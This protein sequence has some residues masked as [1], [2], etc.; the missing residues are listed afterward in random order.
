MRLT[1]K[2]VQNIITG[3]AQLSQQKIRLETGVSFAVAVAK[4]QLMPFFEAFG[5]ARDD[6]LD[7][8]VV[9]DDN[10]QKKK[11]PERRDA[12]G[13]VIA[14]EQWDL[15][16]NEDA[17]NRDFKTLLSAEVEVPRLRRMK[18]DQFKLKKVKGKEDGKLEEQDIDPEIL[19]LLVPYLDLGDDDSEEE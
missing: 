14:Q 10:G 17:W 3:M 16:S 15:G 1:N 8:Y 13:N 2:Q 7:Q 6:L 19:F 4:K 18:K 11:I 9:K 5:D 12:N